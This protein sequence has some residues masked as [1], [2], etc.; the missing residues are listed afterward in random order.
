MA[1]NDFG[2]RLLIFLRLAES[3]ADRS[4]A[5]GARVSALSNRAACEEERHGVGKRMGP[6]GGNQKAN[7]N[8]N[9]FTCIHMFN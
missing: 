3:T 1:K 9:T 8:T 5:V 7:M 2:R 4:P 6:E